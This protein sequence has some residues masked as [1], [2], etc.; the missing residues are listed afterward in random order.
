MAAAPAIHLAKN[1]EQIASKLLQDILSAEGS[2]VLLNSY[3]GCFF[4][5]AGSVWKPRGKISNTSWSL[6]SK[7]AAL[8]WRSTFC[9]RRGRRR[10]SPRATPIPSTHRVP[11]FPQTTV[12]RALPAL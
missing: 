5:C 12:P 6:G 7:V 2:S 11:W 1:S 3:A 8:G 10:P 4:V 9:P